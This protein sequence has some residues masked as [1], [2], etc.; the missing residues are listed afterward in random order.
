MNSSER[1][2]RLVGVLTLLAIPFSLGSAVLLMVAAGG[3]NRLLL[4]GSLVGIGVRG[5]AFFRWGMILDVLGYYLLLAPLALYLRERYKGQG[6]PFITLYTLCGLA[7]V[8]IGAI[9]AI[10]LA[11]VGPDL[12]RQYALA[13]EPQRLT[14]Q[15]VFDSFYRAV[16]NGLWNP[17]EIMLEGIWLVGMG[18]FVRAQRR[19]LGWLTIGIGCLGLIQATGSVFD[20]QIVFQIG[21]AGLVILPLVWL[22]WWGIILLKGDA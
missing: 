1:F 11:A 21:F 8:L 10:I 2:R 6:G 15:V 9:G 19:P 7:Y 13:Q 3:D 4:N 16:Y 18:A 12:M 20:L 22:P 5:A 17:L 14:L